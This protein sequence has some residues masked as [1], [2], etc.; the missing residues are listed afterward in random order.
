MFRSSLVGR[1]G[2][3]GSLP[4]PGPYRAIVSE[5]GTGPPGT[6]S[7]RVPEDESTLAGRMPNDTKFEK[8]FFTI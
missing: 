4:L 6:G 8:F 3:L 2:P 1:F 5:N 7:R